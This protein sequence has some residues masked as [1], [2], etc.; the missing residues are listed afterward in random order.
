[1]Q[2]YL[3]DAAAVADAADLIHR[4][5]GDAE[6]EAAARANR[7]RNLGNHLHFC[8]WRQ[9]ERLIALLGDDEPTGSIH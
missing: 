5:G 3:S 1:M 2:L 9:I 8:R 6:F 4:F 7:S